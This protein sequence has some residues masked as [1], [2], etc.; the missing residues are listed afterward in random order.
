MPT[1]GFFLAYGF[2]TAEAAASLYCCCSLRL[3][4]CVF[5]LGLV[6]PFSRS[7]AF[8]YSFSVTRNFVVIEPSSLL[9]DDEDLGKLLLLSTL[10]FRPPLSSPFLEEEERNCVVTVLHSLRLPPSS[11]DDNRS[12]TSV[13]I[14]NGVGSPKLRRTKGGELSP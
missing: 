6:C 2:L 10:A 5:V 7:H 13:I 9:D 4:V 8:A 12:I 1:D 14:Q 11:S 3:V